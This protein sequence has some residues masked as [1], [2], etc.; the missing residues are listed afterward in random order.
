LQSARP[1]LDRLP[2]GMREALETEL[3]PSEEIRA[4]W[5]TRGLGANALVCTSERALIA[6]RPSLTRW[7]VGI[8]PY[9]ELAG[10]EMLD[11][12]PGATQVELKPR[13]AGAR[14]EPGP[15]ADFPDAYY[16]ESR[17]IVAPNTVIFRSRRR[18]REAAAFMEA[19]IA[20]RRH[21]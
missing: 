6:K 7:T 18:A 11:A 14:D 16:Q 13:D 9:S 21:R 1:A 3:A 10:V 5:N 19:L 2:R 15:F 12:R 17:R 20:E 4:V 8:Y